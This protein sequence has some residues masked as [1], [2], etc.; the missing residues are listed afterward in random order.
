M[1]WEFDMNSSG[2]SIFAAE[3]S[4]KEH[5]ITCYN[6][7]L[8]DADWR[9][10]NSWKLGHLVPS[11]GDAVWGPDSGSRRD[12]QPVQAPAVPT[13][14][15]REKPGCSGTDCPLSPQALSRGQPIH[16]LQV[17]LKVSE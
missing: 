14:L 11:T 5:G 9:P 8:G 15:L 6:L 10:N 4:S 1:P 17:T 12:G 16:R 13:A 2:A 3:C 7:Q